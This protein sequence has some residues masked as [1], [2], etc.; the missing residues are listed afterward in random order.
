MCHSCVR[1]QGI[2]ISYQLLA[3]KRTFI[4]LIDF[5]LNIIKQL[6]L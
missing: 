6:S 1:Q 2:L 4:T 5:F 3:P